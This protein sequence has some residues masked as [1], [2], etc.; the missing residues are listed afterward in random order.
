MTDMPVRL[1]QLLLLLLLLLIYDD[2]SV[3]F[4]FAVR[5]AQIKHQQRHKTEH[6]AGDAQYTAVFNIW[7]DLE[8]THIC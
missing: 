8:A 1:P 2:Q 4:V 3:S 6:L 5:C 7:R